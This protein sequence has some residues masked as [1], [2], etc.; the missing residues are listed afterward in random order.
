M[1]KLLLGLGALCLVGVAAPA[2]A[3]GWGGYGSGYGYGYGGYAD[4][5]RQHARA[6]RAHERFHER[7]NDE[8][9][10][11]HQDGFD[12][13]DDHADAHGALDAAH[14]QYHEEHDAD[15]CAYWQQRYY[16]MLDRPSYSGSYWGRQ[17][18]YGYG[19]RY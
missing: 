14:E 8:H 3:Q 7:L 5:V 4:N 2:L 19:Y 17:P 9:A 1:K 10:M 18:S 13:H 6:C 12:G 16:R 11:E 15:N